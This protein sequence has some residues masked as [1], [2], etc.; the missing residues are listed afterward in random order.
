MNNWKPVKYHTF[1]FGQAPEAQFSQLVASA[2]NLGCE[3]VQVL[4]GVADVAPS[5]MALPGAQPTKVQVYRLIVRIPLS[6]VAAFN[7][8]VAE[9]NAAANRGAN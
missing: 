7:A 1:I 4:M 8:R 5:L 9:A 6:E 2:E 3:F